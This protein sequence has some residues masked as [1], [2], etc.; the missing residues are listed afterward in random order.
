MLEVQE[1]SFQVTNVT[2]KVSLAYHHCWC[3][4][5]PVAGVVNQMPQSTDTKTRASLCS[6]QHPANALSRFPSYPFKNGS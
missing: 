1:G 2:V 5:C 6:L 4:E 3:Q